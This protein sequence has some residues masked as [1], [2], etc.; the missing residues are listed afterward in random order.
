MK[1]MLDSVKE[2]RKKIPLEDMKY[3]IKTSINL[4]GYEIHIPDFEMYIGGSYFEGY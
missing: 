1:N 4:K 3:Q 2:K